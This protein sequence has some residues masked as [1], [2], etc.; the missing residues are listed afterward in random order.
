MD[1]AKQK[2]T[3]RKCE[4]QLYT[5]LSRWDEKNC[6]LKKFERAT[7]KKN[8]IFIFNFSCFLCSVLKRPQPCGWAWLEM[9][10]HT[11]ART[12]HFFRITWPHTQK[13]NVDGRWKSGKIR[14]V[15]NKICYNVIL[16]MKMIGDH[17]NLREMPINEQKHF[18]DP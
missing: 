15:E 4:Q 2:R 1:E 6:K 18:L 14:V 9:E 10:I 5:L 3:K 13:N 17:E 12:F 16:Q 7:R 8:E 11:R